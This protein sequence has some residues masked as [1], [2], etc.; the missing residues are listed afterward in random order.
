MPQDYVIFEVLRRRKM[1]AGKLLE[2]RSARVA[3]NIALWTLFGGF[4]SSQ[5]ALAF[6]R[7]ELPFARYKVFIADMGFAS[8]WAA[9][10]PLTLWLARRFP[11]ERGQLRRSLT[12]HVFASFIIRFF[13]P[14]F[15]EL[16]FI[17]FV[18]K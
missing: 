8:L 13:T 17:Y 11:L 3:F 2:R 7:R 16:I 10:T 5:S 15:R 14:A 12:V 9:L 4:L 18:F 6:M 1:E